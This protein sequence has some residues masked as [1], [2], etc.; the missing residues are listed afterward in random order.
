MLNHQSITNRSYK[1]IAYQIQIAPSDYQLSNWKQKYIMM[2]RSDLEKSL[3]KRDLGQSYR[4]INND[5]NMLAKFVTESLETVM[6]DSE[7]FR[8]AFPKLPNFSGDHGK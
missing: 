6:I 4:T 2:Q 8:T 5:D 7:F 3:H 1:I